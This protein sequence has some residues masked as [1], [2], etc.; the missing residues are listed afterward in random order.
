MPKAEMQLYIH[1]FYLLNHRRT[2]VHFSATEGNVT[3]HHSF[4]AS[5]STEKV[6]RI[7]GNCRPWS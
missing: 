3:G 7:W 6:I 4:L 2:S 1:H 5:V